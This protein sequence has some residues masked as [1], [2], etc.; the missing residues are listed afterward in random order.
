MS[1]NG[2]L[3]DDRN[4]GKIVTRRRMLGAVAGA[5]I[6]GSGIVVSDR[7]GGEPER[8]PSPSPNGTDPEPSENPSG[9][10]TPPFAENNSS[11]GSSGERDPSSGNST[12]PTNPTNSTETQQPNESDENLP[13]PAEYEVENP[14][15]YSWENESN[16]L[17]ETGF[18]YADSGN[19]GYLGALDAAEVEAV[20]SD[21]HLSGEDPNGALNDGEFIGGL[22]DLDAVD[23]T[24]AVDVDVRSGEEDHLYVQLVGEQNGGLYTT[25]QGAYQL[26]ELEWEEQWNECGGGN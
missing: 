22:D 16:L 20:L 21:E 14:N 24:Y 4:E 6:F 5:G 7:F 19:E 8:S 1:S 26:S 11:E 2:D 12:D 3:K 13:S 9:G 25:R 23:G 18:C 15:Q 17:E 10:S